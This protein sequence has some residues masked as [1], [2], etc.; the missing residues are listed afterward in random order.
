MNLN[1][2]NVVNWVKGEMKEL[3]HIIE[4]YTPVFEF[5]WTIFLGINDI[6]KNINI[7]IQILLEPKR[8]HK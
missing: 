6:V 3:K 5:E 2:V 4:N 1:I 8:P 7:Y